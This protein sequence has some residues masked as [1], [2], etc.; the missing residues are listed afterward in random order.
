MSRRVLYMAHPVAPTN[1]EIEATPWSP[2]VDM[3]A[4]IALQVNLDAALRCLAWLRSSF[5]EITFIAPWIATIKSLGNDDS[6]A[7]RAAGLVDDCAVVE[8]CNGIVL[9]GKR[10]SIGMRR[11]MEHG[12]AANFPDFS[13][14]DLTGPLDIQF[15][16]PSNGVTLDE[17]AK[18]A[19]L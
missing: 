2:L 9:M 18:Q 3:R 11:E 13:V 19:K 6:P 8:R 17:Y 15:R 16:P 5:P 12:S 7:L 10:I 1:L 14:Y 4:K